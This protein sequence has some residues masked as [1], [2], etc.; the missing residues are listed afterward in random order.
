MFSVRSLVF[1]TFVVIE[2]DQLLLI[3]PS[4]LDLEILLYPV[5]RFQV[6]FEFMLCTML[7]Y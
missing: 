6:F 5:Y 2:S 7:F 3:V 1:L 4:A